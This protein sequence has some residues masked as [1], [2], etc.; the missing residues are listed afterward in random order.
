MQEAKSSFGSSSFFQSELLHKPVSELT[1]V[2]FDTEATGRHPIISGL[3]EISGLKFNGRGELLDSRTQ[4]INPARQIPEN[5]I[6]VHGISDEM[7]AEQPTVDEVIPDFL[8]WMQAGSS[9]NVFI[10]HNAS[11]DIGFLQVALSRLGLP[12]PAN[13]VLDTLDLA[14]RLFTQ[15]EN[16]KLATLVEHLGYL[17]EDTVFHRAEADSRHVMNVFIEMLKL[18]GPESTLNDLVDLAGVS[19][20]TKPFEEVLDFSTTA[21]RKVHSIGR[22]IQSG[23]DLFIHY[24]GHGAQYRQVTPLSVLYSNRKYYLRAFCHSAGN[25]RTFRVNR[26][27][28]LEP[29]ERMSMQVELK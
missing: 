5:V 20:F 16:H 2:A 24:R 27:S 14:R 25:E 26:I 10:A 22:S 18:L 17:N 4:L 6:A 13:P 7:V 15:T 11:F 1:F 28:E 23:N 21:N 19:F 12:L 8:H 3:V 29:V 9:M